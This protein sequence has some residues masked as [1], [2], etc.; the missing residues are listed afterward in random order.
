MKSI[1]RRSS[2]CQTIHIATAQLRFPVT[3]IITLICLLALGV[4][5][6][7]PRLLRYAGVS[8]RTFRQPE[9]L[10][11]DVRRLFPLSDVL[12]LGVY[13][14]FESS[15]MWMMQRQPYERKLIIS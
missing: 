13:L 7:R 14:L 11:P 2:L 12:P 6:C 1:L 8:G 4:P 15:E 5:D 9:R 3:I 10:S